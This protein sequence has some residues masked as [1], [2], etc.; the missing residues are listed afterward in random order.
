MTD[1]RGLW[2]LA[3]ARAEETPDAVLFLDEDGHE[4][5][6]ARLRADAERVAAGLAELGVELDT[7]V[8]WMLPTRLEAIVLVAA[9][10]RVGAVQ[11]PIL[12]ILGPRELGFIT[13]QTEARL[14]IVPGSWRGRDY[15]AEAA[16]L[17]ERHPELRVVV[18]DRE[19][20]TGTTAR[21]PAAPPPAGPDDAP[22][23]WVFYT[24]GTTADPKGARHTDHTV[25]AAAVGMLEALEV[26]PDDRQGLVFPFTHIG[27]ITWLFTGLITGCQSLCVEAFTP[28]TTIPALARFG[29]TL[30]G[31]GT[32]FHLAYLEAQRHQPDRPIFPA[33]RAFP[34]GAA[35][36]SPQLH[37]ELKAELGGV[38][39]VSGWGLTE[40]PILTMN[41]VRGTDEQ[42]AETEGPVT[43][44]VQL[45]VVDRDGRDVGP[46]EEGELR[47]RGP[48]VCRGFV[49]RSL[50]GDAFDDEG[51]FR[52]GDLGIVREDGH[53][54]ITGRLKDVII[55]KAESIS[56]KEVED[57]LFTHPAVG[58]AAVV[59]LPDAALGERACAVVVAAA[60]HE[61][62]TLPDLF[63][64][65]TD[66]GLTKQK[67]PEQL[68][69]V[70]VLPRNASG[71][72]LKH[73]LR[74]R[75]A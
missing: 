73:E 65:L 54:R 22:V 74:A 35:P 9:L 4:L 30:A 6:A 60:G 20:P 18:A 40:A 14:L 38:G 42:L 28:A 47:A 39:I 71:K 50:E 26:G 2:E 16:A 57:L 72:V 62:P 49:D 10:A 17:A 69:V 31:A 53:V 64:F 25:K 46:G 7:P 15:P 5:S 1:R 51:W 59:G 29:V 48:Q 23:R 19:L 33:V 32:T 37:Y 24:S 66:A 55:R 52:T 70:D 3:E 67:I 58:D 45:R 68:E 27:G 12:P 43:P 36:K 63:A 34:G 21:L 44:G 56:A 61:A 13:A 41:T 8:S 11:N 75:F